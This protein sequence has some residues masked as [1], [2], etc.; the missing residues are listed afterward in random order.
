MTSSWSTHDQQI[1]K[2]NIQ[3]LNKRH[4]YRE[5]TYG[6]RQG[7]EEGEG[8]R[9]G[10]RSMETHVTMC[11]T[12]SQGNLLCDS[13]SSNRS[14]SNPEGWGGEGGGRGVWVV[15]RYPSG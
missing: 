14:S 13:G 9:N 15:H 5:Q 11:E 8:E 7:G 1:G 6:H 2:F 3:A 4:R 10:E 12:D